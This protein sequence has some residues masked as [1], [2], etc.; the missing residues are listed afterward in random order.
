MIVENSDPFWRSATFCVAV[1]APLKKAF[2]FEAIA[3]SVLL[4]DAAVVVVIAAVV[5]V[6]VVGAFEPPH[7]AST[8]APRAIPVSA[9]KK[10]DGAGR[11]ALSPRS[12]DRR[13]L[14]EV[15]I[16]CRVAR[17]K[18]RMTLRLMCG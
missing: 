1:V 15:I 7:A 16:T 18:S 4:R 8:A 6:V 13:I 2:Q 9:A 3:A 12:V 11:R 14:I 5:E 10:R 17:A